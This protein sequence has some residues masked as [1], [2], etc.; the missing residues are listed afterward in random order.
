MSVLKIIFSLLIA[1]NA[2]AGQFICDMDQIGYKD[3]SMVVLMSGYTVKNLSKCFK[4]QAKFKY[5]NVNIGDEY[6][7]RKAKLIEVDEFKIIK[8][9]KTDLGI[10]KIQFE[11]KSNSK[12]YED[13][14][15]YNSVIDGDVSENGCYF[16]D[17]LPK[18]DYILKS[19][20]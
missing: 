9:E 8:F 16:F 17:K 6:E 3:E 7:N 10:V 12:K 13:S 18:N 4:D 19:C 5:Y 15:S 1:N 20:K 14:Y 2:K 11:V